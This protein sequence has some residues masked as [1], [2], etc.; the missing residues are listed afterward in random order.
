MPILPGQ[1]VHETSSVMDAEEPENV[2][3]VAL[4]FL[5]SKIRALLCSCC[6]HLSVLVIS[7]TQCYFII[8]EN[9]MDDYCIL[10]HV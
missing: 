9:I 4:C 3:S 7:L 10:V 1:R 5:K 6:L 2:F 8:M